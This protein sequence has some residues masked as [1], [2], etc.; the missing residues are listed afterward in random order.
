MNVSLQLENAIKILLNRE[1]SEINFFGQLK[2]F[3]VRIRSA[4]ASSRLLEIE[5][6]LIS[7]SLKYCEYNI[8]IHIFSFQ[9][10]ENLPFPPLEREV[11]ERYGKPELWLVSFFFFFQFSNLLFTRRG[12]AALTKG[13]GYL[14]VVSFLLDSHTYYFKEEK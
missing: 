11:P 3:A 14:R 2:T 7:G 5:L 1:L 8:Y 6:L 9:E 13:F 10:D 12:R 4:S